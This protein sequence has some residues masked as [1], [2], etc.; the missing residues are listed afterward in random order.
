M[1]A[2]QSKIVFKID[3]DDKEI[4]RIV[5][6]AEGEYFVNGA[7]GAVVWT[8][9]S[10]SALSS[11][12]IKRLLS[13]YDIS[14]IV[15]TTNMSLGEMKFTSVEEAVETLHEY[16]GYIK[17]VV[18]VNPTFRIRKKVKPVVTE[19]EEVAEMMQEML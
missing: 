13:S 6:Q 3:G 18:Y 7:F 12:V 11:Y 4:V 2:E 1:P 10:E 16:L 14:N 17:N 8:A 15:M 5:K 9:D 19:N